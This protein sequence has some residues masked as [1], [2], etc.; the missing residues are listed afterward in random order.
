M[1]VVSIFAA[2]AVCL[3]VVKI[4]QCLRL[5]VMISNITRIAVVVGITVHVA[6]MIGYKSNC[7][8][9]ALVCARVHSL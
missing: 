7:R 1:Y 4:Q 9:F 6:T 5:S 3:S 2:H 8:R